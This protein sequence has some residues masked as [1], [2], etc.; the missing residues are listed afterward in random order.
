MVDKQ[1]L[2]EPCLSYTR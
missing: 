2:R 1:F